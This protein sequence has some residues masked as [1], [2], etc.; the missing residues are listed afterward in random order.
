MENGGGREG[1]LGTEH[2][3]LLALGLLA[4]KLRNKQRPLRQGLCSSEV[5]CIGRRHVC[6]P[7]RGSRAVTDDDHQHAIHFSV[8]QGEKRCIILIW[9][10]NS[11]ADLSTISEAAVS[12]PWAEGTSSSFKNILSH[13]GPVCWGNQD[14]CHSGSAPSC[15]SISPWSHCP[16]RGV[17]VPKPA[18]HV[19]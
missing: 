17:A 19:T 14:E 3:H 7:E 18:C 2:G 4:G 16:P 13:W 11:L 15:Q 12:L 9:R 5:T 1:S 10:S 8:I 6:A